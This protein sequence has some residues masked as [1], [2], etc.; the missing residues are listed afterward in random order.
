M[1]VLSRARAVPKLDIKTASWLI[2]QGRLI[3][4]SAP[5]AAAS[6]KVGIDG[7]H[8]RLFEIESDALPP[9]LMAASAAVKIGRDVKQVFQGTHTDPTVN[10]AAS[11]AIRDTLVWAMR[12]ITMLFMRFTMKTHVVPL[13]DWRSAT[14]LVLGLDRSSSIK[15]HMRGLLLATCEVETVGFDYSFEEPP[16]VAELVACMFK[17]VVLFDEVIWDFYDNSVN[18]ATIRLLAAICSDTLVMSAEH[19]PGLFV[20]FVA[21]D[22]ANFTTAIRPTSVPTFF[23]QEVAQIHSTRLMSCATIGAFPDPRSPVLNITYLA[24]MIHAICN[25]ARN[26]DEK[27]RFHTA[28]ARLALNEIKPAPGGTTDML[29]RLIRSAIYWRATSPEFP[30]SI[31]GPAKMCAALYTN[32]VCYM[33]IKDAFDA[34]MFFAGSAKDVF[35]SDN[36]VYAADIADVYIELI[37][38]WSADSE[39]LVEA[40][41]SDDKT[42]LKFACMMVL[43]CI[44][45]TTNNP[46]DVREAAVKL[47][48][49]IADVLSDMVKRVAGSLPDGDWGNMSDAVQ[50]PTEAD[51]DACWSAICR[52]YRNDETDTQRCDLIRELA[53]VLMQSFVAPVHAATDQPSS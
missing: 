12:L 26:P 33:C 7:P 46:R 45:N 32:S 15:A 41:S 6:M 31:G 29:H 13:V 5:S 3:C 42:Q 1:A 50:M 34:C 37:S 9:G 38:S 25:S 18:E 19:M 14:A 47:A 39:Q 22:V 10:F 20:P 4:T 17:R 44:A 35:G 53:Q 30:R 2:Q 52:V 16:S 48:V 23:V 36:A 43:A 24:H 8:G 11:M 27:V 40:A 28:I 49:Q 51:I 21:A